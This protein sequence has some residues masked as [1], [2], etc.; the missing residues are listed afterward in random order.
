MS[1]TPREQMRLAK[2]ALM[3][4][5]DQEE[6]ARRD[7]RRSRRGSSLQSSSQPSLVMTCP[8][9]T[10]IANAKP[11]PTSILRR[12]S[13]FHSIAS[14][15]D[16][17]P[18]SPPPKAP[19][20]PAPSP[21]ET[22]E[23]DVPRPTLARRESKVRF[24][25]EIIP[26]TT[27]VALES[28]PADSGPGKPAGDGLLQEPPHHPLRRQSSVEALRKD[29]EDLRRF[30]TF[31]TL[32]DPFSLQTSPLPSRS[33]SLS[34]SPP[35]SRNSL[36][37]DEAFKPQLLPYPKVSKRLAR[38]SVESS[39]SFESAW[40]TLAASSVS[41]ASSL[42]PAIHTI[43][44]TP[45]SSAPVSASSSPVASPS[46]PASPTSP[47]ALPSHRLSRSSFALSTRSSVGSYA[48]SHRTSASSTSSLAVRDRMLSDGSSI[49]F[50]IPASIAAR[51]ATYLAS[52][53]PSPAHNDPEGS[54]RVP[55]INRAEWKDV[56]LGLSPR[57]TPPPVDSAE[58]MSPLDISIPDPLSKHPDGVDLLLP[59]EMKEPLR[60]NRHQRSDSSLS[61]I[62]AFPIPPERTPSLQVS[63]QQGGELSLNSPVP[64]AT[65]FTL[66]DTYGV[67]DDED[68]DFMPKR[69][70]SPTLPQVV[71]R[72]GRAKQLRI[73]AAESEESDDDESELDLGTALVDSAVQARILSP[74]SRLLNAPPTSPCVRPT[75]LRRSSSNTASTYSH[76]LS[77]SKGW[78]GSESEE[79][80]WLE[81]VRNMTQRKSSSSQAR[82]RL[83]QLVL[84]PRKL[85]A[86]NRFS[87]ISETS[88]STIESSNPPVTPNE[89][90]IMPS[91][92]GSPVNSPGDYPWGRSAPNSPSSSSIQRFGS[93]GSSGSVR[94]KSSHTF[95]TSPMPKP[96]QEIRDWGAPEVLLDEEWEPNAPSPSTIDI[97][98]DYFSVPVQRLSPSSTSRAITTPD[99]L[100]TPLHDHYT[101]NL[102]VAEGGDEA[103]P[104]MQEK[105]RCLS[106]LL[107]FEHDG[108]GLLL[109]EQMPDLVHTITLVEKRK[110]SV[111]SAGGGIKGSLRKTSAGSLLRKPSS[112][113]YAR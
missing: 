79:E 3:E 57:S 93:I 64:P 92:T 61:A 11:P 108:E 101:R 95:S 72:A 98:S 66:P 35:T 9:P 6:D 67:G 53:R 110:T 94:R 32:S 26:L 84:Q 2:L 104:R 33:G 75:M 38:L 54:V 105:A 17:Q 10:Q 12:P 88:I 52:L 44:P 42:A 18:T 68:E 62:V 86:H 8:S 45:L 36:S 31:S 109:D 90:N 65:Y 46:L 30:S 60:S 48:L 78:S 24:S 13:S 74:N 49:D 47:P 29:L 91:P 70:S 100:M 39:T 43:S 50:E 113:M 103:T 82:P 96:I 37:L 28:P 23:L 89:S 80:E 102:V 97:G 73:L 77:A 83:S 20:P 22:G 19:L 14:Q 51:N 106:P 55:A 71:R 81:S 7:R 56:D 15:D 1:L 4:E 99:D 5:E 85:S 76:V 34:V 87:S 111:E 112:G 41:S 69:S 21:T 16:I 107:D 27:S 63:L 40:N 59:P 25:D 58:I